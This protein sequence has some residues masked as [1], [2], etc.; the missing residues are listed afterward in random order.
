MKT[1]IKTIKVKDTSIIGRAI[2]I[3]VLIPLV[4]LFLFINFKLNY[5][6]LIVVFLISL[7][8]G[9]LFLAIY[10][11]RKENFY[12]I[13]ADSNSIVIRNSMHLNWLEVEKIETFSESGMSFSKN[14]KYLKIILKDD[15]Q[16]VLNASNYDIWY[17]DLKK[18]LEL[19]KETNNLEL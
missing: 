8:V 17:K 2:I 19:L 4:Y 18:E 12:E 7:V 13:I 14:R 11:K 10:L 3:S 5:L 9:I 16:I 6:F 1:G 15:S